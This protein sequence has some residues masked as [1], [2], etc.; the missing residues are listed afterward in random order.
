MWMQKSTW[1]YMFNLISE[2]AKV[3]LWSRSENIKKQQQTDSPSPRVFLIF[4]KTHFFSLV[5]LCVTLWMCVCV[6]ARTWLGEGLGLSRMLPPLL[7]TFIC[8]DKVSLR[9]WAV[10]IELGWWPVSLRDPPVFASHK[11]PFLKFYLGSADLSSY[12]QA[13]IH[14]LLRLSYLSASPSLLFVGWVCVLGGERARTEKS[15][16]VV[17]NCVYNKNEITSVCWNFLSNGTRQTS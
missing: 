4:G 2:R 1:I 15:C 16:F 12:P 7:S 9:T 5:C 11:A 6:C 8:C 3:R 13:C 10:Q 17:L 14:V